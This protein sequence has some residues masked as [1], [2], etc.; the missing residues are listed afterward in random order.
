VP[1]NECLNLMN[2]IF[3]FDQWSSKMMEKE[4]LVDC[5]ATNGKVSMLIAVRVQAGVGREDWGEAA[6]ENVT[7]EIKRRARQFGN[8]S[9][10]CMYSKEYSK[11]SKPLC[12]AP[13]VLHKSNDVFR[14]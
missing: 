1:G 6:A 2:R 4:V 9:G 14:N 11:F 12:E 5:K 13:L 8:A 3:G 7:N 10:N